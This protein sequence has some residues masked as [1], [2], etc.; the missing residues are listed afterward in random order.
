VVSSVLLRTVDRVTVE[1]GRKTSRRR[2]ASVM[3]GMA[4]NE[5]ISI[6]IA[7][8]DYW[9]SPDSSLLNTYLVSYTI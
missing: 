4:L 6:R 3:S 1:M 7:W 9:I 8:W 5:L 2:A